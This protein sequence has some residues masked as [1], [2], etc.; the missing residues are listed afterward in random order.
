MPHRRHSPYELTPIEQNLLDMSRSSNSNGIGD[1]PVGTAPNA[2]LIRG[3]FGGGLLVFLA[4]RLELESQLADPHLAIL[5]VAA[6]LYGAAQ[7]NLAAEATAGY[8]VAVGLC[9]SLALLASSWTTWPWFLWV[10]I[11][12]VLSVGVSV[13]FH[14]YP[15]VYKAALGTGVALLLVLFVFLVIVFWKAFSG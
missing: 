15:K 10:G 14:R 5:Y 1:P 13:V 3:L 11:W 2:G 9:V 8:F 12:I 6:F 7:L 4:T